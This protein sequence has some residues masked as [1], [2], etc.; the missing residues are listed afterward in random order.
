[1]H[2]CIKIRDGNS[3]SA[4]T[5]FNFFKDNRC[6]SGWMINRL[7]CCL[8][9]W[10]RR[11]Q[12]FWWH[13]NPVALIQLHNHRGDSAA[14]LLLVIP[15]FW[16]VAYVAPRAARQGNVPCFYHVTCDMSEPDSC[17]VEAVYQKWRMAFF[18]LERISVCCSFAAGSLPRSKVKEVWGAQFPP[19][20]RVEIINGCLGMSWLQAR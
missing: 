11:V 20:A 3:P 13:N 10:A 6:F 16:E 2:A 5:Q 9:H 8:A 17:I 18:F 15:S 1:M 4:G 12:F 7:I 14:A 19:S